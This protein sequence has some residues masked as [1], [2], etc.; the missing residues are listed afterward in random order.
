VDVNLPQATEAF[1]A[2]RPKILPGSLAGLDPG[3]ST[4]V[5]AETQDRHERKALTFWMASQVA[6]SH[7]LDGVAWATQNSYPI[8]S[9]QD[10]PAPN[11][12]YQELT[13]QTG[14]T[15][16][17]P[18]GTLGTSAISVF[19]VAQHMFKRSRVRS[20]PFTTMSTN[21]IG[22]GRFAVTSAS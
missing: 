2:A 20:T 15:A 17:A 19:R 21:A 1:R 5:R 3:L 10:I 16:H 13:V 22:T 12:P 8:N 7:N 9:T 6:S 4:A 11:G 18:Q 14:D